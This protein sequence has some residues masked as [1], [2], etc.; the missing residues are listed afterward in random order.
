[1]GRFIRSSGIRA[2]SPACAQSCLPCWGWARVSLLNYRV[3]TRR[4]GAHLGSVLRASGSRAYHF[5][6]ARA[7]PPPLSSPAREMCAGTGRRTASKV[8]NRSPM[9]GCNS[10]TLNEAAS[11]APGCCAVDWM[12]NFE[13]D[14]MSTENLPVRNT[15]WCILRR[16]RTS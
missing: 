13:R 6:R 10:E 14:P 9:I 11:G 4:A 5:D 8:G 7:C 2:P 16:T 1:M 3:R 12:L 15:Q